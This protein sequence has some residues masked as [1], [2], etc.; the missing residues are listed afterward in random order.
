MA[1]ASSNNTDYQMVEAIDRQIERAKASHGIGRSGWTDAQWVADAERLMNEPDGAITSLLNG[2][3]MALLRTVKSLREVI[4]DSH[5]LLWKSAQ[6]DD[7]GE[8]RNL[9]A[10]AYATLAVAVPSV[11]AR[12]KCSCSC[13]RPGMKVKHAVACCD[14]TKT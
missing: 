9:I 11:V 7:E 2:H 5:G 6:E 8:S 10:S 12:P 14:G 4:R 3:V 1:D 13:H